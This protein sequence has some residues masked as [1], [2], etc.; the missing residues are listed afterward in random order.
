MKLK[1]TL[2][3]SLFILT[4]FSSL[5]VPVNGTGTYVESKSGGAK[6]PPK[7]L[8]GTRIE[9]NGESYDLPAN[10][11]YH[12]WQGWYQVGWTNLSQFDKLNFKYL[13]MTLTI[14]D[15]PVKLHTW[16]RHYKEIVYDGEILVDVMFKIWYVEFKEDHFAPGEY[17]FTLSPTNV[18]N[19]DC[20]VT[21]Y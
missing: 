5:V 14:N 12:I 11:S 19:I 8:D 15:E 16:K 1:R 20:T 4:T 18:P 21:F 3:L 9:L 13:T 6:F 7:L 10:E 17:D 2:F